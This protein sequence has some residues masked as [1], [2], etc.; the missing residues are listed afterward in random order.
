MERKERKERKE[1]MLNTRIPPYLY[2]ALVTISNAST[3]GLSWHVR[4]AL[5]YYVYLT[6]PELLPENIKRFY[7][8]N[9]Q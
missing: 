2:D 4:Q 6:Q 1:K 3:Q 5:T 8:R 7:E 9:K